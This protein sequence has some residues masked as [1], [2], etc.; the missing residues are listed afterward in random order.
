MQVIT[1]SVNSAFTSGDGLSDG[2]LPMAAASP[3]IFSTNFSITSSSS[4]CSSFAMVTASTSTVILSL[5]ID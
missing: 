4:G 1:S 3:V 5:S 2:S